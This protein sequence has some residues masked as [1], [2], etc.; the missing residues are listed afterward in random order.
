MEGW[1]SARDKEGV[2]ADSALRNEVEIP[3]P[4]NYLPDVP[5]AI[6]GDG[7]SSVNEQEKASEVQDGDSLVK[8]LVEKDVECGDKPITWCQIFVLL[9]CFSL[10]HGI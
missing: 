2:A 5:T 4:I 7:G 3:I 1:I 9:F 10:R 8:S 6:E